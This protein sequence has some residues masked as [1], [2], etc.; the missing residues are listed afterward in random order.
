MT[1]AVEKANHPGAPTGAAEPFLRRFLDDQR[2]ATA[3]EYDLIVALI[4][5]VIIVSVTAV[6]HSLKT[7]F[8][9]Q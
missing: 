1:T 9:R 6:G 2:G 5:V 8:T 7:K 4:G 3:I